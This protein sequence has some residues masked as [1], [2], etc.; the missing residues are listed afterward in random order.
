[1]HHDCCYRTALSADAAFCGECGGPIL[2]CAAFEECGGLVDTDGR[3]GVCVA[4]ELILGSTRTTRVGGVVSLPFVVRNASSVGRPLVVDRLLVRENGGAWR[5]QELTWERLDAGA[6]APATVTT[7]PLS[8]AGSHRI[9]VTLVVSSRWRW[10]EEVMAF[11]AG[12]ELDVAGSDGVNVQQ[13][14]HVDSEAMAGAGTIYAPLRFDGGGPVSAETLDA[15]QLD[16]VRASRIE[17][18]L[19]LRG[20]EAGLSVPRAVRTEWVGFPADS[21]PAAGPIAT[22]D[23]LVGVGRSRTALQGG[24]GDVRLLALDGAGGVDEAGSLRISRRHFSLWIQNDRLMLRVDSSRGAEVA[25][26]RVAG[27][28][29]VALRDGDR[30]APFTGGS[31]ARGPSVSVRFDAHHGVV[32]TVRFT[33]E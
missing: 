17:R 28:E 20:D 13:T 12:L 23:G 16:L 24:D 26:A 27:G 5:D 31:G 15:R 19:G 30:F 3:C 10:R 6:T 33:S 7:S 11:S 18:E 2:R 22:R 14:I 21:A 32:H 9:D 25:G 4:P 1:M 29:C 8:N